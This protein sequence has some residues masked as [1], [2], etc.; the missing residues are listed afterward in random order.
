MTWCVFGRL[1]GQGDDAEDVEGQEDDA[2]DAEAGV[3]SGGT[4]QE[5]SQVDDGEESAGA[6]EVDVAGVG[7]GQDSNGIPG[8]R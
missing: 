4:E 2:V 5:A 3:L 6:G 1:V 7:V 8:C